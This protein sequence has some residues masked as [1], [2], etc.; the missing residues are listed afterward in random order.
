MSARGDI[1][2]VQCPR[3]VFWCRIVRYNVEGEV[4]TFSHV[5]ESYT[6]PPTHSLSDPHTHTHFLL[7]IHPFSDSYP[8][9]RP[10]IL[11]V[12]CI[13]LLS[14]SLS[15]SPT[16]PPT[17]FLNP[18]THFLTVP[19]S[20]PHS[21]SLLLVFSTHSLGT[22]LLSLSICLLTLLLHLPIALIHLLLHT[23]GLCTV[24]PFI[25]AIH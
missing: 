11:C 22:N 8:S 10:L 2:A 21:L 3:V 1:Y 20:C 18:S 13:G 9:S 24:D 19:P 14:L 17:Y 15:L 5:M 4:D 12:N 23:V 16:Y 7:P 25:L 6:R